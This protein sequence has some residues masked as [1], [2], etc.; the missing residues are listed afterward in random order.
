MKR[1]PYVLF[2]FVIVATACGVQP[3]P[4]ATATPPL[5]AAT[6]KPT[7][8]PPTATA[9][10]TAE[11]PPTATA[12]PTAE[13]SN[14]LPIVYATKDVDCLLGTNTR[15]RL[16]TVF[17]TGVTAPIIGKHTDQTTGLWYFVSISGRKCYVPAGDVYQYGDLG[18]IPEV[19]PPHLPAGP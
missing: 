8:V 14:L 5:P 10:P 3:T 18:G 11:V 7:E 2:V 17:Y 12:T 1:I 15:Y 16:V 9:T 6:V 19:K 4:A 13:V